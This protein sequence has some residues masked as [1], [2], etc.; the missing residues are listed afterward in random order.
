MTLAASFWGQWSD[1]YGRLPILR[2][3]SVFL[4]LF[5]LMTAVA[6]SI[7]WVLFIRFIVG[8]YIAAIPQVR[9]L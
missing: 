7:N 6:P 3:S 8:A 9:K 4:L 2:L 5:G 1:K